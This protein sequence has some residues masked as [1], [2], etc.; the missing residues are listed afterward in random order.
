MWGGCERLS[1]KHTMYQVSTGGA[2]SSSKLVQ[3]LGLTLSFLAHLGGGGLGLGKGG[4]GVGGGGLGGSGLRGSGGGWTGATSETGLSQWSFNVPHTDAALTP[5]IVS[6]SNG[7]QCTGCLNI[8][9]YLQQLLYFSRQPAGQGRINMQ[10]A[11]LWPMAC[12]SSPWTSKSSR[13]PWCLSRKMN[14]CT[15]TPGRRRRWWRRCG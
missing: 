1:A 13:A 7:H 9:I 2:S 15:F 10:P 8:V 3:A 14:Q 4:G 6:C 11:V 12:F 5:T